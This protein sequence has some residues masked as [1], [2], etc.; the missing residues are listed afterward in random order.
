MTKLA[1]KVPAE[2]T[3]TVIDY[4]G[5]ELE[6]LQSHVGGW[7]EQ[8]TLSQGN[9]TMF[10]NEEGKLN[11]LPY[12][13]KATALFIANFPTTDDIIVGD[14]LITG[15]VDKEGEQL[16]LD[17]ATASEIVSEFNGFLP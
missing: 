13:M 6:N 8:I 3:A 2:G 14:V 9:Y 7:I 10:V 16:G 5:N 12:N 17:Q 4:S 11:G 15:G 1:V